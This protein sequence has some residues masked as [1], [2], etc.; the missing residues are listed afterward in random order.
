VCANPALSR[1]KVDRLLRTI[2]SS[3]ELLSIVANW[4]QRARL[5]TL[6]QQWEAQA[7][8]R[9]GAQFSGN[10]WAVMLQ[11]AL[12]QRPNA[13][14]RFLDAVRVRKSQNNDLPRRD[15]TANSAT[16]R[17]RDDESREMKVKKPTLAEMW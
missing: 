4:E 7:N 17:L 8:R 3:N 9:G 11:R 12:R 6:L 1:N 5:S 2:E 13:F 10:L 16:P 15:E 14:P